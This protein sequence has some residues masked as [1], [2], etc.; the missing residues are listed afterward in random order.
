MA[1]DLI[2][3]GAGGVGSAAAYHAAKAGQ[4][5]LLLEQFEIDHQRGSSYGHSRIIRYAYNHPTYVALAKVVFP[6]WHALAE[7]AGEALFTQTGGLD[8][9]QVETV[10]LRDTIKTLRATGIP[11]EVLSADELNTRFPQFRAS[12]GMQALYQPDAGILAASK[13]VLAHVRLARQHGAEVHDHTR[14]TG[15]EMGADEVRV[16]TEHDHF[17]AARLIVAPGSWGKS[18]F[19]QIGLNLPLLPVRCQENYFDA[20]PEADF[21]PERLPA[22]IVHDQAAYGY[23]PYGM[24]SIDGSGF[25][26]GLH[27]GPAIEDVDTLERT[28]DRAVVEQVRDF[29]ARLIPGGN[30]AHRSSRV[31]LYTMTPDHHFIIDRHPQH[32]QI[33]F[34]ASCSGHAFKFST[35]IGRILCDLV[36]EGKS[37]HPLQLFRHDRF[38]AADM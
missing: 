3:I 7:A 38:G 16:R 27:G 5:V 37:D 24:A 36:F 6:M 28:P 35:L 33:A 8:I 34:S 14:V 17:D 22:F 21:T 12:E 11:H 29:M 20:S 2:V 26:V 1:Y 30:G 13:C 15:I 25:K 18:V 31:C 9:G 32:P 19:A 4:R 10:A 23:E